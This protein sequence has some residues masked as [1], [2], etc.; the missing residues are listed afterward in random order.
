M[1]P[2]IIHQTWKDNN[3]PDKWKISKKMWKKHHPEWRYILWTD[4][5]IRDYIEIGY[6]EF[7]KLFDSYKYN[8][9]RVDMIRYF[10][11]KDLG[12]IYSDLDLYPTEK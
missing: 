4:K 9:Q 2:K 3:I 6:P 5:M 1:I 11:L 7:L 8:I 10:I 12:G